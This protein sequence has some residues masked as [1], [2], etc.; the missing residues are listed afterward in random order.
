MTSSS[1]QYL[2]FDDLLFSYHPTLLPQFIDD[3]TH[4]NY[5]E[6]TSSKPTSTTTS[7]TTNNHGDLS[8]GKTRHSKTHVKSFKLKRNKRLESVSINST[9]QHSKNFKGIFFSNSLNLS[10][11]KLTF[12]FLSLSNGSPISGAK[13]K[14]MKK[15]GI[16]KLFRRL[17]GSR[18][19]KMSTENLG[20]K[21]NESTTTD[22]NENNIKSKNYNDTN[23]SKV[24]DAT[25]NDGLGGIDTDGDTDFNNN[26]E[27]KESNEF[28][29]VN[30]N[31]NR[32]E[33]FTKNN[34]WLKSHSDFLVYYTYMKKDTLSIN[35]QLKTKIKICSSIHDDDLTDEKANKNKSSSHENVDRKPHETNTEKAYY[36]NELN[37]KRF[38]YNDRNTLNSICYCGDN[39]NLKNNQENTKNQEPQRKYHGN[40]TSTTTNHPKSTQLSEENSPFKTTKKS[41]NDCRKEELDGMYADLYHQ[42]NSLSYNSLASGSDND[43]RDRGEAKCISSKV[44]VDKG[45][46]IQKDSTINCCNKNSNINN[47]NNNK[48]FY[49]NNN[50]NNNNNKNNNNNSNNTEGIKNS[51]RSIETGDIQLLQKLSFLRLATLLDIEDSAMN[52]LLLYR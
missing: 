7:T 44:L 29:G 2:R 17:S 1:P 34:P 31:S 27:V 49:N 35:P 22:S 15:S 28:T 8:R 5:H 36:E 16:K 42:I 10:S 43:F 52:E 48:N 18:K 51:Y 23:K 19:Y 40:S 45:N 3:V 24:N 12:S 9:P 20:G 6:N 30:K 32:F 13:L 38:C 47:N 39:K 21:K 33:N 37:D 11:L 4:N 46:D 50:N 26:K 25:P 41:C 14:K